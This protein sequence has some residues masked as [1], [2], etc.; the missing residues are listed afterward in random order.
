M[1]NNIRPKIEP[2]GIP[3]AYHRLN[4]YDVISYEI[5]GWL[6]KCNLSSTLVEP[7]MLGHKQ[8][9]EWQFLFIHTGGQQCN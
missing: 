3:H 2:W 5:C 9:L 8:N 1:L 6:I 4:N 7:V